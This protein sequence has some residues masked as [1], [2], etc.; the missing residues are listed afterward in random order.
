MIEKIILILA[1]LLWGLTAIAQDVIVKKDGSIILSNVLEVTQM[2]VKFKKNSNPNGP[3][4]TIDKSELLSI[5]YENGT[6]DRFGI[7]KAGEQSNISSNDKQLIVDVMPVKDN[8]SLI[9]DYNI[10]VNSSKKKI[11]G[12]TTNYTYKFGVTSNSVLSSE[13]L[14]ISIELNG[15]GSWYN[16]PYVIN[17]KN[18]TDGMIYLDLANCFKLYPDGSYV[19]YF[20]SKQT[21]ISEGSSTIGA[22]GI[23]AISN[24]IGIGGIVGTIASGVSV[25][26]GNEM[27]SSMIYSQNRLLIIPPHGKANLSS[28]KGAGSGKHYHVISNSEIFNIDNKYIWLTKKSIR[29]NESIEYSEED[30][31]YNQQYILLYSKDLQFSKISR[32]TFGVFVQQVLGVD[33]EESYYDYMLYE[34]GWWKNF[35]NVTDKSIMG[36]ILHRYHDKRSCGLE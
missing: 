2:D 20:D 15:D 36:T 23:G 24:A 34:M 26:T 35:Q 27:S 6:I 11:G 9:A 16:A 17:I 33:I 25:G 3:I 19:C 21:S 4:Y 29:K 31:P 28:Y 13:D 7:D 8:N 12:Y 32:I 1:S 10:L 30:S 5:N 22:L 14:E 18:K